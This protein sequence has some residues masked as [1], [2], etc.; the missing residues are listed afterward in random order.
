MVFELASLLRD[1]NNDDSIKAVILT[2]NGKGFSSGADLKE[3][4]DMWSK[5]KGEKNLKPLP[6]LII[7][8]FDKPM[9]AA[10][11]GPAIGFGLTVT[12]LCDI[13]LAAASAVMSMR[14]T[15]VGLI[16]EAGSPYLLPRIVGLAN[17]LD[18]SL[19]AKTVDANE[20]LRIGLVN[21]VV[22]D[23]QLE[24]KAL[25]IAGSIASKMSVPIQVARRAFYDSL[26]DSFGEQRA[27][28]RPNFDRCLEADEFKQ[29]LA[30]F[31]ELKKG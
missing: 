3:G 22:A 15:E 24:Q 9:I 23:D 19:T 25:E 10:I 30:A 18:L 1:I 2:G 8:D 4:T 11:N 28:E 16:P 20:A 21:Y 5:L 12:L 14:F 17:A 26:D 29:M 7:G 31:E 13:R 6:E 27:K